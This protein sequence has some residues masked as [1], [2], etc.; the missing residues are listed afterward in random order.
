MDL[1]DWK[2]QCCGDTTANS[3]LMVELGEAITSKP[4][5]VGA[6]QKGRINKG[7]KK[8]PVLNKLWLE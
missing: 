5:R 7:E 1:C 8:P 3:L 6:K 2:Q 4:T